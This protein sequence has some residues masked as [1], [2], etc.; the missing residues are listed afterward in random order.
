MLLKSFWA[1]VSSL[2]ATGAFFCITFFRFW[3][4][5]ERQMAINK[6]KIIWNLYLFISI[7]FGKT[8]IVNIMYNEK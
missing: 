5:A 6:S 3:A 4:E 7:V 8:K 2:V 1:G